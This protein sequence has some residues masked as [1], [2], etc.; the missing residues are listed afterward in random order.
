[1]HTKT[2]DSFADSSRP[3]K[4]RFTHD[5]ATKKLTAVVVKKRLWNMTVHLPSSKFD[6]R[7]SL[8]TESSEPLDAHEAGVGEN[9]RYK[10]RM[11]YSNT[12]VGVCIDLTQVKQKVPLHRG[13]IAVV[14]ERA[15]AFARIGG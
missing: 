11:S 7:I 2:I 9:A 4:L 6:V 3:G 1:M 5:A 10:D 14:W 15:Q 13:A 8:N 12:D